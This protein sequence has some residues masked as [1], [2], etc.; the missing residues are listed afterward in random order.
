VLLLSSQYPGELC[1]P[2]CSTSPML[3][4]GPCC[5]A[6][7]FCCMRT[8]CSD[9]VLPVSCVSRHLCTL[10]AGCGG[11]QHLHPLVNLPL[12]IVKRNLH[13]CTAANTVC[14]QVHNDFTQRSAEHKIQK[15]A[16]GSSFAP[17]TR[18]TTPAQL[19]V[20]RCG[21]ELCVHPLNC[22]HILCFVYLCFKLRHDSLSRFLR[23]TS[24]RCRGKL[25][26]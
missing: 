3:P 2:A 7:P 19:A 8:S 23:N 4:C 11:L 5:P 13:L 14:R 24:H 25:S 1:V 17:K 10:L 12:V 16:V 21:V 26:H 15:G 20:T 18:Q 6:C 9:V 22:S